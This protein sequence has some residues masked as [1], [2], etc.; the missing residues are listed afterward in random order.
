MAYG[1]QGLPVFGNP[2]LYE[3]DVIYVFIHN[4]V[5]GMQGEFKPLRDYQRGK[6]NTGVFRILELKEVKIQ[7][8]RDV[9]V[10]M[11]HSFL[12]GNPLVHVA[13]E[14]RF[15]DEVLQIKRAPERY[16]APQEEL[17]ISHFV[18]QLS[19]IHI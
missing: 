13:G 17:P 18:E 15:S 19:L 9:A 7:W 11:I 2:D 3:G 10:R 6:K 14:L 12:S 5:T 1:S 4:A 8:I 16:P